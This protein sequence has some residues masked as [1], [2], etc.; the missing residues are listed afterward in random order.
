MTS[1]APGKECSR[2][3]KIEIVNRVLTDGWAQSIRVIL[4]DIELS[5]ENL[6]EL[7]QFRPNEQVMVELSPVQVSLFDVKKQQVAGASGQNGQ[8]LLGDVGEEEE[9]ISFIEDEEQSDEKVRKEW[10]FG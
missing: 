7:K 4:E 8:E 9:F 6:L 10:S 5:D 2:H 1:C 3:E